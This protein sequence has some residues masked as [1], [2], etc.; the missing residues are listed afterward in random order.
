RRPPRRLALAH[1]RDHRQQAGAMNQPSLDR[2]PLSPHFPGW[3]FDVTAWL[4]P[5]YAEECL[6]VSRDHGRLQQLTG[7]CST[8]R[9]RTFGDERPDEVVVPE[10][11]EA[12]DR[13]RWL[14]KLYGGRFR[15]LADEVAGGPYR[16]SG[17]KQVALN[18]NRLPVG[19]MYEWHVDTNEL[20][21][22]LFCPT[23]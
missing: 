13:L 1:H 11:R 23:E 2:S 12:M 9:S 7:R 22:L 18:V 15:A 4:P 5:D 10:G 14:E 3:R 16:S 20:T 19:E 8:S 17:N 6:R 21:G